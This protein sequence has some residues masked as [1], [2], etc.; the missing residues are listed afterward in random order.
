[1]E[2]RI[3]RFMVAVGA[4]IEHVHTGRVLLIKRAEAADYSG[5][6]WEDVTGRMHQFEE[7]EEALRREIR[8]ECGL[9]V[10]IVKPLSVF[11]LFR[12]ERTAEQ[13]LIGIVFWC[14]SESDEVRLSAEHSDY[15]WVTASEALEVVEH[16]GIRGDYEAFVRERGVVE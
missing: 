16:A 1:M 14:R 11:H 2:G 13:E 3:G 7:P 15:R 10:E 8:E 5:G 9:E 12:G 6:I 4:V